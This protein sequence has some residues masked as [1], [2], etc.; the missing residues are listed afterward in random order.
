MFDSRDPVFRDPVG[1]VADGTPVHFKITLTRALHCSAARLTIKD[2]FTGEEMVRGM[3]WCGMNGDDGEWWECHFT[4]EK[5]GLF[6]YRFQIDTERGT[7]QITRG[8]GG[9]GVFSDAARFWQLTAYDREFATPDWLAGGILYQIFPDRF[10]RSAQPKTGVPA[11]RKLHESWQE[12]PDWRPNEDG[13]ITNTDYF[14]GDLRGIEEKLPYLQSLGVTCLYLNPIFESHSN[15]RYDTADYSKIDPL[16]GNEQD[17][18][19]LCAAAEKAGIRVVLDGVFNHTGSDSVYFNR[20]DRY[21]APG[22]YHSKNSPYYPWYN[23]QHWPKEYDCWWNF[24]TLPCVNES[25][26]SYREYINGENG[27]IR[28]WL[29]AGAA[30]WRLDVADELP[31]FF[32]DEL[33]TAAKAQKSDALILGEVWEDASN[34]TAYGQRRRYLLGNQLDSVMNY[35]F[36]SAILGFLTGADAGDMMEIILGILENYPPQV[37]RLL[38]NH[39]GTHDTERALTMLAGEP[40]DGR[41]REWQSAAHLTRE[42]RRRGLRL[43]RLASLMQFT[44]PG[45]PCIYYG[46][47]AG[48]EGYRDPFNR[49]CYPWGREEKELVEWYRLLGRLRRN[50]S[51]LREGDFFP[52][53]ADGSCMGY[54]R[55]DEAVG[56]LCVVNAGAEGHGV[57]VPEEWRQSRAVIG[58]VPDANN[59]LYLNPEDCA[60]LLK[61]ETAKAVGP[62]CGQFQKESVGLKK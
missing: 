10:A 58:V 2:G 12:Q 30:G 37:V 56:L 62:E 25:E 61:K 24:I 42:R 59:M 33:R 16:L 48:M 6:F 4:P 46:D 21:A 31:D 3:F 8:R 45:V 9:E 49:A 22:A 55:R 27:I 39:I 36:R 28:K 35:P 18:T 23:F 44:L 53:L 15:H 29:S 13:R 50:C 32:L 34:K 26:P 51:A 17:F 5:P 1:A 41:G 11:D 43:M 20:Q 57:R 47:E 38:M 52:F 40:L 14:G 60:V 19:R 54:L 7:L